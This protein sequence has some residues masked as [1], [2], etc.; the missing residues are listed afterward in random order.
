MNA[1]ELKNRFIATVKKYIQRDGIDDLLA[2][3]ETTDFYTSPASTRFHGAYEGGLVEHSLMVFNELL[4]LTETY[5]GVNTNTIPRWS[6][7]DGAN[8]IHYTIETLAIVSLFHD[9]CKVQNY[10]TE[11]RNVK[12]N[13]K[14]VQKPYYTHKELLPFGGHGSKSM[15][16]VMKYMKLTEEEAIAIVN[17]MGAW[18]NSTYGNP[19]NSYEAYPLAWLLHVADES[20]TYIRK[21]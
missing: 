9:L 19:S 12:E 11:M 16:L 5:N 3:L 1:E 7:P 21:K 10:A 4:F 8:D 14:W 18:D 2:W 6:T 17:H 20:A 13:D 15:Y